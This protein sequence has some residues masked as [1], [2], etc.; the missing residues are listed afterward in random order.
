MTTW[1]LFL[2]VGAVAGTLAGLF[3]IGGGTIIVPAVI[4]ALAAQG[5]SPEV[6]TH[7]ALATSLTTIV[8]TSLSSVRTHHQ[9]GAVDWRVVGLMALGIVMG[10]AVGSLLVAD[11]PG[12]L[13]QKIIGVFAILVS[14]QMWFGLQP[15]R[16]DKPVGAG[17]D[18]TAGGVIGFASSWFGI[19][20]GTFTVPYLTWRGEEMRRAVAT[21]AACGLPIAL[22][23]SVS[24]IVTGWGNPLLPEW[25]TGFVFWPAV[26]GIG[27]ASVPFAR[28]GARLAHSLD[29]KK[30]KKAF[31]V[32]LALVGIKFLSM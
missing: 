27:L 15:A 17:V 11:V 12:P 22:T 9:K 14:I 24:N 5:V 13:L 23:G 1:L 21:S 20:G 7:M 30:L 26:I 19:G 6:A 3:G 32:L 16:G 8:F 29:Q 25:C 31:A 28:V 2:A 10:T 4:F 18:V